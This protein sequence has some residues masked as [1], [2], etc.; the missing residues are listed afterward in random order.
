MNTL[1]PKQEIEKLEQL[2]M[3]ND[4]LES[5][6]YSLEH[7]EFEIWVGYLQKICDEY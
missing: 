2:G 6:L 5:M 7:K 4:Q 3:M 1:T